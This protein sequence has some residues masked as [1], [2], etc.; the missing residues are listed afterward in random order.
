MRFSMS[1]APVPAAFGHKEA[2]ERPQG[3]RHRDNRIV[4]SVQRA[5]AAVSCVSAGVEPDASGKSD[6]P[7]RQ[8]KVRRRQMW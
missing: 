1:S 6:R 2:N 3:I 4:T 8:C 7:R 5:N